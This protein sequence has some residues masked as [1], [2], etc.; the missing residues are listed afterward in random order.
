MPCRADWRCKGATFSGF[1]LD[2]YGAFFGRRS[3]AWLALEFRL[4]PMTMRLAMAGLARLIAGKVVQLY[5]FLK[6]SQ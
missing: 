1:F 2:G 6:N 3:K 5:L 4:A